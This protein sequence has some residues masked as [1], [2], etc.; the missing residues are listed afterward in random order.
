M[1]IKKMKDFSPPQKQGYSRV[2]FREL[3]EKNGY[4]KLLLITIN[5]YKFGISRGYY[6]FM[7]LTDPYVSMMGVAQ[8][9]DLEDNSLL[10]HY[11][12][13]I[14]KFSEGPWD[15]PPNFPGLTNAI[16]QAV[17]ELRLSLRKQLVKP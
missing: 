8:M 2:D 1:D 9:I 4:G 7:P 3:K 12:F 17:E 5:D 6:G 13:N 16:Y 15:E 10:W 14:S 11:A